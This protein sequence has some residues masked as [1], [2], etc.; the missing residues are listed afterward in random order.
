MVSKATRSGID[1]TR[2]VRTLQHGEE[3][4]HFETLNQC[5]APWGDEEEWQRRYVKFP[6]FDITKNV[7][8]VTVD[9]EW[10][11]GVTTWYREAILS[12]GRK[13]KVSLPGDGYVLPAFEDKGV[14]STSMRAINEV[15]KK[16]GAVLSFAFP[17]IYGHSA[18]ALSKYGFMNVLYPVAKVYVLKHEKFLDDFLTRTRRV[19]LNERFD[20]LTVKLMVPIDKNKE[21]WATR[22]LHIEKGKL[23]EQKANQRPAKFD[24]T[25]KSNMEFLIN[26]A[27]LFY[28]QKRSLHLVLLGALLRR[29]LSLRFSLRFIRV[30]LGL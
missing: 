20:N 5:Y 17:A 11:G 30:F 10:A 26:A 19:I 21:K 28:R 14:F 6:G 8:L 22:V 15:T 7:I 18:L 4:K 12:N 24:L 29:R 3:K 25:I 23:K 9:D 16:E 2:K 27:S 13:T 1:E